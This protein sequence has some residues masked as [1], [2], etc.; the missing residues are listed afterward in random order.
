MK[1]NQR[2]AL[3]AKQGNGKNSASRISDVPQVTNTYDRKVYNINEIKLKDGII[4]IIPIKIT[5]LTNVK[6]QKQFRTQLFT[7]LGININQANEEGLALRFNLIDKNDEEYTIH[8]DN[9]GLKSYSL[10][11]NKYGNKYEYQKGAYIGNEISFRQAMNELNNKKVT[12][13]NYSKSHF[14]NIL[15]ID[16]K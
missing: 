13:C 15:D 6:T 2:K 1:D 4:D 10:D 7:D 9:H 14:S 5:N 11:G 3:F 12:N 16:M 8:V